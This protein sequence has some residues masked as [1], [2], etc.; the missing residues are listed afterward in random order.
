VAHEKNRLSG[1]LNARD[2]GEANITVPI[3]LVQDSE[4]TPG[5]L[6]YTPFYSAQRLLVAAV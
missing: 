6:F 5:F 3:V 4:K 1:A 2:T